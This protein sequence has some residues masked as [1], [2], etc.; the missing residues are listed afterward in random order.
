MNYTWEFTT[1]LNC[2]LRIFNISFFSWDRKY[3]PIQLCNQKC[4]EMMHGQHVFEVIFFIFSM[5]IRHLCCWIW[6]N[7]R[8]WH[9][10]FNDRNWYDEK[11]K[12][13]NSCIM[14]SRLMSILIKKMF[15]CWLPTTQSKKE[16]L[17]KYWNEA[18]NVKKI[19]WLFHHFSSGNGI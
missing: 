6:R 18:Y 15:S 8:H 14:S 12:K 19:R 4:K 16:G 1:T 9:S 13:V 10:S 2:I 11:W 7:D 5:I 3:L 17:N